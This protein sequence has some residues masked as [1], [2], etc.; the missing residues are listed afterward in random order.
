MRG[1]EGGWEGREIKRCKLTRGRHICSL[2][3]GDQV[4]W[5]SAEPW[6]VTDSS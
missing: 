2:H 3:P 5:I 1:M 6:R 4:L